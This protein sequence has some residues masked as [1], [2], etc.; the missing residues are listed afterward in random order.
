MRNTKGGTLMK[1]WF[2]RSPEIS[3][4]LN[5]AFCARVLYGAIESYQKECKRDFPFVLSYLVLPTVLHKNT[6]ERIKLVTHMEVWLQRNPEILI[7][8]AKRAKSLVS[9]TNEAMEFLL[10]NNVVEIY[11]DCLMIVKPLKP[12]KL[13]TITDDEML[14]CFKKADVIGK[15]F[16]R[17][18]TVEN[19][20]QS[21]G[22]R[23]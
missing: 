10:S 4:L 17:N 12:S 23:P 22:V 18:G 16:A 15:W 1:S 14:D 5:P 6:R 13:R 7:T 3:Y 21:W 2:E 8:F 11:N 20:Y 9:I 19:I